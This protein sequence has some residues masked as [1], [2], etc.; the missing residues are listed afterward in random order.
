MS[1][2]SIDV[3]DDFASLLGEAVDVPSCAALVI[4]FAQR[5]L[6]TDAVAIARHDPTGPVL[7]GATS[8]EVGA[9]YVMPPASAGWVPSTEGA[10]HLTP[11]TRSGDGAPDLCH[12]LAAHGVRSFLTVGLHPLRSHPVSLDLFSGDVDA[13]ST[14]PDHARVVL[15][16]AGLAMQAFDQVE[17]LRTAMRSRDVIS[18]AQ[19]IVMARF[20]LSS[21]QAISYLR[22]GSQQSQ[23]KLRDVAAQIVADH[24]PPRTSVAEGPIGRPGP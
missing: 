9:L 21:E 11:D 14:C 24:R 2:T 5:H 19:G 23:V 1:A 20:G 3:I 15:R 22:R 10:H 4:G 7:L 12:H 6:R 8:P 17:N 16:F 18:Q 13:F